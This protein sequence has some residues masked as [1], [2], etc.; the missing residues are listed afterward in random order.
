[1]VETNRCIPDSGPVSAS[2]RVIQKVGGC[3]SSLMPLGAAIVNTGMGVVLAE[4]TL[5][6]GD[7]EIL[8]HPVYLLHP[9]LR[10]WRAGVSALVNNT[11]EGREVDL[12]D[13]AEL[14]LI[15]RRFDLPAEMDMREYYELTVALNCGALDSPPCVG[16][17]HIGLTL[18]TTAQELLDFA[19]ELL[20]EAEAVL[21]RALRA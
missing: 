19:N 7:Q 17:N 3:L 4:M 20:L 10:G 11:L 18:T 9:S 1:M 6:V 8:T 15:A 12:P 2:I 5:R 16:S 14:V 13:C 21:P